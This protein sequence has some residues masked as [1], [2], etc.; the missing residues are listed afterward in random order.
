MTNVE[1]VLNMLAEVSTKELVREKNPFGLNQ[2]IKI[3]KQGGNV[4]KNARLDLEKQLGKSVISFENNKY[5]N[6][7]KKDEKIENK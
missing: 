3:A 2:N 4:A 6:F 7:E 5:L 1:L